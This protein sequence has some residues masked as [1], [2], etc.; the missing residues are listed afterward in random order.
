MGTADPARKL[1]W[2]LLDAYERS[3]SF[4]RPAPWKQ[5][6]IV[7]L[8][9]KGFPEI[10]EP[11]GREAREVLEHAVAELARAGALRTVFRRGA[12]GGLPREVR[13]GPAEV[14]PAY[15]AARRGGFR[16]LR[17]SLDRLAAHA[18]RLSTDG[19]SPDWMRSFVQG[20]Q[21]SAA[22]GDLSPVGIAQRSRLKNEI[23]EVEDALSAAVALARGVDDWERYVSARLF[24]NSKR[25]A[26]IR[27]RVVTFLRNA[28]PRWD[29]AEVDDHA[30]FLEAY[31]IRRRP[32]M[33]LCAGGG[34]FEVNGHTYHLNDFDPSAVLPRF[35]L[36]AVADG[37]G[38]A[39]VSVVTTVEN[40]FPFHEYVRTRGGPMGLSDAG[41]LVVY[42]G[43]FPPPFVVEFLAAL[44]T[45]SA[46]VSFRH[47]GDADSGGLRIW[48]YLRERLQR[49]VRLFRTM[50]NWVA[51][52]P[53]SA[54][55]T[56][57][58]ADR[59][60]LGR[61]EAHLLREQA[62]PD[63]A[64]GLELIATLLSLGIKPEQETFRE[65]AECE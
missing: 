45:R 60:S 26:E 8:D 65:T 54:S 7:R 57:T 48:W 42:V 21:Q 58:A 62:T 40:E 64:E 25:L 52:S 33:L 61:L 43:G 9:A 14:E 30:A 55:R 23:R 17:E 36:T 13:L 47:W 50:A 5:D 28:D 49:P 59:A 51:S 2:K 46:G 24:D 32:A 6:V 63:V 19:T 56:L 16:P 10:Y 34:T 22:A 44:A 53:D 4:G 38:R 29:G 31:G 3:V 41:E 39:A 37:L 1:L 11:D 12:D 20:V 27:S 15:S 18:A 35:W